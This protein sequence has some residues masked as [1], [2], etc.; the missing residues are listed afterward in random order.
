MMARKKQKGL[1]D[2]HKRVL[3]VLELYTEQ[4]GYPPLFE[5]CAPGRIYHRLR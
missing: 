2:K 5:K 3:D 1:S 4:H